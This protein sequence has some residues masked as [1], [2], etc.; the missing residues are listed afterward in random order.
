VDIVAL[1]SLYACWKCDEIFLTVDPFIVLTPNDR[2]AILSNTPRDVSKAL[3]RLWDICNS[4]ETLTVWDFMD[5]VVTIAPSLKL[6]L[7]SGGSLTSIWHLDRKKEAAYLKV[8]KRV[9]LVTFLFSFDSI[10]CSLSM[11]LFQ[12]YLEKIMRLNRTSA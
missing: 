5:A 9:M 2:Q 10:F 7:N 1:L 11:I 3:L 12:Q 4:Y 6:V 8:V